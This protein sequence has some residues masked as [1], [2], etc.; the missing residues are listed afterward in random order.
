MKSPLTAIFVPVILLVSTTPAGSQVIVNPPAKSATAQATIAAAPAEKRF[1][2]ELVNATAEDAVKQL[3]DKVGYPINVIYTGDSAGSQL[4]TLQL[5]KVTLPE[6][7]AAVK[8]AGIAEQKNGRPGCEFTPVEGASNI[9]TFSVT[10]PGWNYGVRMATNNNSWSTTA[11]QAA[12]VA[13]EL[14]KPPMV[15]PPP[16]VQW[17]PTTVAVQGKTGQKSTLFFDLSKILDKE[18]TIEDVTTA[19]RTGWSAAAAD[20]KE[21]A[22]DALK[23]HQESKLL[24]ATGAP[25]QLDAVTNIVRLLENRRLPSKDEQ[26][27]TIEGLRRSIEE[28]AE[29]NHRLQRKL[30]DMDKM[31]EEAVSKLQD[32]VAKLEIELAKRS[33]PQ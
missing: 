30:D 13:S 8:A 16:H 29:Q 17:A 12:Q 7:F 2:I 5:R 14:S 33:R 10:Q 28:A 4:P 26:D 22:P 21:P 6:F 32:Q 23:F 15:Y 31:K 20:G 1:D 3:A 9:Y 24:I 11:P 19:I 27:R 25:E 18:L